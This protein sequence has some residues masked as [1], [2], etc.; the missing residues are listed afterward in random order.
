M[1]SQDI[2][3]LQKQLDSVRQI[4]FMCMKFMKEIQTEQKLAE[5]IGLEKDTGTDIAIFHLIQ[6]NQKLR[7]ENE[8]LKEEKKEFKFQFDN[9][10]DLIKTADTKTKI[11]MLKQLE[12]NGSYAVYDGITNKIVM[13]GFTRGSVNQLRECGSQTTPLFLAFRTASARV[14]TWSFR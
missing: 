7:E 11:D 3:K 4:N 6:E 14:L 13:G 1:N 5:M 9:L 10:I 2:K 12:S 8:K